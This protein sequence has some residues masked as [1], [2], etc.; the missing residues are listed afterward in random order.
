[1]PVI[2]LQD[3]LF[4]ELK[5]IEEQKIEEKKKSVAPAAS[6]DSPSL[7]ALKKSQ[8]TPR[9]QQNKQEEDKTSN[10]ISNITLLQLSDEQIDELRDPT[11]DVQTFRLTEKDK[12]WVKD[13]SYLLSKEIRRGSVSQTDILRLS[14]LLFEKLLKTNK[15]EIIKLIE[16]IK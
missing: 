4:S 13:T 6:P 16:R 15:P 1:V 14:F 3:Y 10:I 11:N 7:Q 12:E 9:K 5:K 8:K 2:V